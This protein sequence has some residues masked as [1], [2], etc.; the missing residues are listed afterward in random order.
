MGY[1]TVNTGYP[2]K[3]NVPN[4]VAGLDENGKVQ[5][6]Q[7]PDSVATLDENGKLVIDQL[8]EIDAFTKNETLTS[9][10]A[11]L[12]GLTNNAVP[13]EVFSYLGKYNQHW[14]R[15]RV[16]P[17]YSYS[18]TSESP[19]VTEIKNV[20]SRY[21]YRRS[22]FHYSSN[23]EYDTTEPS[24]GKIKLK[25]PIYEYTTT[26]GSLD[27]CVAELNSRLLNNY[28]TITY[29]DVDYTNVYKLTST[30]TTSDFIQGL[31]G[32]NDERFDPDTT[33]ITEYFCETT[34]NQTVETW[35]YIQS[36]NKNSYPDYGVVD[37]YEYEYLGFPFEKM[38]NSITTSTGYYYG[39]GTYG[40]SNK[41]TLSFDTHPIITFIWSE[42]ESEKYVGMLLTPL[43]IPFGLNHGII[44]QAN[45]SSSGTPTRIVSVDYSNNT[46]SWFHDT[47]F[48]IQLNRN[49][50]RYNY[51]SLCIG[52]N[53]N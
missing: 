10:V 53:S 26:Y 15:R 30:L 27:G 45:T 36:S 23:Y 17:S 50:A 11:S 29:N 32:G 2:V 9:T 42:F 7:I 34:Q 24:S 20:Y 38:K 5:E 40:E 12:F 41:N 52:G 31:S 39:T 13:N 6:E 48:V 37:G 16:A 35:E 25:E 46:L 3:T 21:D 51:I 44:L 43:I 14:W 22:T 49:G 33:K 18:V 19:V 28:F 47:S 4:G 1:G 8:P